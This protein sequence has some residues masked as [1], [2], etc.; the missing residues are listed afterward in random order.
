VFTVCIALLAAL[1]GAVLLQTGIARSWGPPVAPGTAAPVSRTGTQPT[2]TPRS[3]RRTTTSASPGPRGVKDATRGLV[4]PESAPTTVWIPRIHVRSR[5]V[6]LGVDHTG[7]MEVPADPAR[8]GWYDLGPTPG[9]LGPAVIA[10]HVT[11]NRVPA[12]FFKL[13]TLRSGDRVLVNRTDG[14]MA[15]FAVRRVTRF[16]KT[17]FP[18][19]K[20]FGAID[21]AGLRLV[22]CGGTYDESAH[23]YLA[24]VVAF[25]TLVGARP[26]A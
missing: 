25:A 26:G 10:G 4:L 8:P 21:H 3:E 18:T 9:A 17:Q 20:V 19:R 13:A 2:A 22:T 6:R 7:A 5:L 14:T 11:W 1:A 23:R 12:V 16:E 15:V 24:N